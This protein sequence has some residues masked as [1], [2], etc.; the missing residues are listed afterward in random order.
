MMI[1]F[2]R[3]ALLMSVGLGT[4][5]LVGGGATGA[6]MR[7]GPAAR[8]GGLDVERWGCQYQNIDLDA[9]ARSPLD[10][11]VLDP[12]VQGKPLTEVQTVLLRRKPD[13]GRRLVL[14]YVSIGEAESYRDY[15]QA[16]WRQHPPPWLGPEN[17][18]WPGSFAVRFWHPAWRDMLLGPGGTLDRILEAGFDGVFLDRVDAY[19]DWPDQRLRAQEAMITLVKAVSDRG[20]ARRPGFLVVGQN[21]EPLL[22]S[23]TYLA[24]IDAVSKESLLYNL[25]GPGQ[26]NSDADVQ[27]SLNYL[28]KAQAH[29]LPILAIE[30]ADTYFS[31]LKC[32]FQLKKLGMTPF[33]G[34]KLLDAI[35]KD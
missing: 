5:A 27:W 33:I 8:L 28:R 10:L 31:K 35:P 9:V 1:Q 23:Q 16:D 34:V 30:Y 29:G 32:R 13:G 2:N 20:R 22:L 26:A 12:V 24:A 14:A 3:R 18:N 21:A 4:A 19:G 6:V 7:P 17:A 11:I 15:W 25:H